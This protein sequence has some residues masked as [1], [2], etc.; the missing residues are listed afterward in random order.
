MPFWLSTATDI[1]APKQK[2]GHHC[3]RAVLPLSEQSKEVWGVSMESL[4]TLTDSQA[5]SGIGLPHKA[6]EDAG[7]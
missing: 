6:G 1:A 7:D 4:P 3:Q 2:C 5:G